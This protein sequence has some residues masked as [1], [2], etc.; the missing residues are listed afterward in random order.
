MA[1]HAAHLLQHSLHEIHA[2]DDIRI[3]QHRVLFHRQI[4]DRIV[5][6]RDSLHIF[7]RRLQLCKIY[8]FH[9][10]TPEPSAA[11]LITCPVTTVVCR[12]GASFPPQATSSPAAPSVIRSR[13]NVIYQRFLA[14]IRN[15]HLRN[16]PPVKGPPFRQ[17]PSLV[18]SHPGSQTAPVQITPPHTAP[19]THRLQPPRPESVSG[20]PSVRSRPHATPCNFQFAAKSVLITKIVIYILFAHLHFSAIFPPQATLALPDRRWRKPGMS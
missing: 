17:R 9:R 15:T 3:I 8:R 10:I 14:N 11:R 16:P 19:A 13:V 20:L 7:D 5:P 18:A 6:F 1:L 12:F 4:V 2:A